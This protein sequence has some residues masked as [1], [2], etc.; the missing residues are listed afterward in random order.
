M[1]IKWK[2]QRRNTKNIKYLQN[3]FDILT[4]RKGNIESTED[5]TDYDFT[6]RDI[7][8]YDVEGIEE[9]ISAI[10][11]G[12]ELHLELVRPYVTEEKHI[13][14][15]PEYCAL[16]FRGTEFESYTGIEELK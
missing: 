4:V 5:D 16:G 2:A 9:I 6:N 12:G 13:W 3:T 7:A 11:I 14:E 8:V 10:R 15:D 1:K